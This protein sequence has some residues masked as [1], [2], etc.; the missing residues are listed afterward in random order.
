MSQVHAR[1][2][3]TPRTPI[4]INASSASVTA[5]AERY[6]IT[7]ATARKWKH[8]G[9]PQDCSHRPHKLS[10]TLTPAQEVLVVEVRRTL[11][12]P[13][14]DLPPCVRLVQCSTLE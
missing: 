8:R 9:D 7:V 5:L 1:A 2:R 10:T 13:L 4:E 6:N 12:L 14:D 11:L 3:T